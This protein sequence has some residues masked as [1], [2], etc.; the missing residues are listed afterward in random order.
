MPLN[1]LKQ[2]VTHCKSVLMVSLV[3]GLAACGGGSGGGGST[4]STGTGGSTGIS[5]G[6]QSSPTDITVST[7]YATSVDSGDSYYVV[8]G[9]T[10]GNYYAIRAYGATADIT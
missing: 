2:L 9:L 10:P 7:P 4:G 8:S 6:T 1:A 3:M 5:D